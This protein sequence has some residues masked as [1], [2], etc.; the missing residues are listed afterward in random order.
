M[1]YQP[2]LDGLR[3][4]SVAAVL[5]YHGGIT[6]LPGGFLGVEVFFVVSGYLITSLLLQEREQAGFTD[7]RNFWMRRARRL[8]PAL[9]VVLAATVVYAALFAEDALSHLKGDVLAALTYVTN[10]WLIF[11]DQSYFDQLGRP[12]LLRHLWSLAVEEQWYL[13]WPL[14]FAGGM[15]LARNRPRRLL[16]PVLAAAAASTVLMVWLYVPDT[17]PSRV[18]FGTDTRASG[19]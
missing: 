8:L 16:G 6:W 5:L 4:L 11:S 17:D 15:A 14:V 13:V 9:Y 12:P 18:Y 3:A 7:L 2:G 10:W 19:L 1:G